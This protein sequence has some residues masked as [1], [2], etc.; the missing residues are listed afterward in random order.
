MAPLSLVCFCSCF[1]SLPARRRCRRV[2]PPPT[3]CKV[4]HAKYHLQYSRL[5]SCATMPFRR[6]REE[7]INDSSLYSMPDFADA[8]YQPPSHTHVS[9]IAVSTESR[10]HVL[11]NVVNPTSQSDRRSRV[12]CLFLVL[13]CV[14]PAGQ[15]ARP[16]SAP[17]EYI[18]TVAAPKDRHHKSAGLQ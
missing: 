1:F 7:S 13:C 4:R 18:A 5:P 9:D 6:T 15:L 8:P 11:E 17:T 16:F 14:H 3:C 12:I 10:P 2:S